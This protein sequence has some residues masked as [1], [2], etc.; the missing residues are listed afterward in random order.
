MKRFIVVVFLC[1]VFV[2]ACIAIRS[3]SA[4]SEPC[5]RIGSAKCECKP[6]CLCKQCIRKSEKA[7]R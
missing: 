5:C 7:P 2:I 3:K 6:D 4:A 1:W